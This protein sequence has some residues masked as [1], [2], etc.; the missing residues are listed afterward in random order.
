MPDFTIK[1]LEDG[2]ITVTGRGTYGARESIKARGGRWDPAARTW[3]LPSGTDTGF[4]APAPL[5]VARLVLAQP[6]RSR[7]GRCCH[8][9]TCE[10]DPVCPQGPM[11]W[12]CCIHG[13][14]R[15]SWAGD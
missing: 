15:S 12:V 8:A 13:R 14:V 10:F 11:W 9:A 2:R 1:T 6:R 7:D 4:L 3:T 5:F